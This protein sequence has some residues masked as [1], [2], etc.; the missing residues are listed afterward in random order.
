MAAI[1][2]VSRHFGTALSMSAHCVRCAMQPRQV[3]VKASQ[4]SLLAASLSLTACHGLTV[5]LIGSFV[6]GHSPPLRR[7]A[8]KKYTT[9]LG[10]ANTIG[11]AG[12]IASQNRT[13]AAKTS[14]MRHHKPRYGA[15]GEIRDSAVADTAPNKPAFPASMPVMQPTHFPPVPFVCSRAQVRGSNSDGPALT[16]RSSLRPSAT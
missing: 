9:A 11:A 14:T 7:S 6:I 2:I 13:P 12:P 1:H 4:S 10:A 15:L 3:Q 16:W 5:R 8:R